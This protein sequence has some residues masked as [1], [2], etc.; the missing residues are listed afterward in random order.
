M[1]PLSTKLRNL[2]TA[3]IHAIR[4]CFAEWAVLMPAKSSLDDEYEFPR[5]R[6]AGQGYAVGNGFGY[7]PYSR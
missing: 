3:P 6:W 5:A 4:S 2:I 1:S 7:G